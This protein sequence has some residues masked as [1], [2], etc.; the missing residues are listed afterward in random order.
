MIQL[1]PWHSNTPSLNTT[2]LMISITFDMLDSKQFSEVM[3]F[4][5]AHYKICFNNNKASGRHDNFDNFTQNRSFSLYYHLWLQQ[6]PHFCTYAVPSLSDGVAMDS[7]IHIPVAKLPVQRRKGR[8][9]GSNEF[10]NTSKQVVD[11]LIELSKANGRRA[12]K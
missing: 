12:Y 10:E 11:A 4:L 7:L 1:D 9:H 2:E 6:V 5:N 8:K 3:E